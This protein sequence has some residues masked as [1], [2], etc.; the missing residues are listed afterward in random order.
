MKKLFILLAL[1]FVG[2]LGYGV[3][4]SY[5][6]QDLTDLAGYQP[7]AR[8]TG[9]VDIPALIEKAAKNRQPITIT[10][11]EMNTWLAQTIKVRQEGHLS[12]HV[13]L[14]GVWV[15]FDK[16][17]DGRVEIILEREIKG[18]THTTSKFFR[19]ERKKREDGNYT[20]YILHEGGRLWGL[21][22]VGGRFGSARVP[23]GFL[24]FT[25]SSFHA[26]GAHFKQE[27]KWL[28]NDIVRKG[29]G[30]ILFEEGQMRIDFPDE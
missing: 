27:I 25:H 3:Y 28:E 20:S 10:E 30:R 26:L 12:E 5:Q 4:L 8:Q 2:G 23:L 24:F 15:R 14:K 13:D 6:P 17:A 18:H 11:K 9:L 7:A 16:E 29:N 19:V 21:L 1:L 22:A